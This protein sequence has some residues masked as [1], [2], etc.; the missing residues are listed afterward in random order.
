MKKLLSIILALTMALGCCGA[1]AD[2]AVDASLD[3][4]LEKGQ[5]IMGL[6][7][8]FPPM[9]YRDADGN[10]VGFDIDL[11]AEVCARMGIELVIQPISWDAKTLELNSGNIDCIWNGFTIT[12]SLKEQLT[13]SDPYLANKQVVVVRGDS[14]V[15]TLADLAGK[16]L[17]LQAGSSA[18][19][20]LD[21]F[22]EFRDSV[23]VS[24][25]KDNMTAMLDLEK[26]GLDA[27]LVD[28]I[29]AGYY[30]SQH[31]GDFRV[32]SE[33]LTSEE[34]G[35]GFRKADLALA[36][37]VNSTL[38]DMAADGKLAEIS[39]KWFASDIT[40]L[41]KTEAEIAALNAEAPADV[42]E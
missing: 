15:Q 36:E 17:G 32:L 3:K 1:C 22:P 35:I 34:Y 12:D 11:A 10:V 42:Q 25:F 38:L 5:L 21:A 16:N 6:D 40:T 28:V 9:G 26:G 7:D 33:E 4:V 41:G 37:K 29:V 30:F 2:A 27:V 23:E 20:A 18:V 31:E 8:S 19:A 24:E 13:F 39:T 14:E